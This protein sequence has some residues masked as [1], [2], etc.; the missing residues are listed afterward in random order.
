M[1]WMYGERAPIF[2]SYIRAG[3]LNL[4]PEHTREHLIRAVYEGVAYNIRWIIEI[5][6]KQYKFPLKSLRVIGGGALGQP[7]MQ[8]LSDVTG[9]RLETVRNPQEAGAVGVAMAAAVGMGVY[10][11][12]ESLKKVVTVFKAYEPQRQHAEVYDFLYESYKDIYKNLRKFYIRLNKHR[13][14][15]AKI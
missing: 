12:F 8:I 1:P 2:D 15:E 6:E 10:P 9:K 14:H 7:W 3:F 5:I 4:T 11:D 13:Y